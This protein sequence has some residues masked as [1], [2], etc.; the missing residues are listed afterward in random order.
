MLR[1]HSTNKRDPTSPLQHDE[2][3]KTRSWSSIVSGEPGPIVE[4]DTETELEP[5]EPSDMASLHGGE[6]DPT[7]STS[8]AA[9][10]TTITLD[11]TSIEAIAQLV[12]SN[13]QLKIN[14]IVKESVQ[15]ALLSMELKVQS[16]KE[17]NIEL[18]Q[19]NA[20]L[21]VRVYNLETQVDDIEQY[22][23]RN[24]LRVSGLTERHDEDTDKLILDLAKELDINLS[25]TDIDR[26]H[27]LG[28]P[29]VPGGRPRQIIVKFTSY[30][31][32]DMLF[33]KRKVM[34]DKPGFSHTYIN[35]DLTYK[36]SQ[37]LYE[38]RQAMKAKDIT[39]AWSFDG[40]LYVRDNSDTRRKLERQGDLEK[41]IDK[42]K[43]QQTHE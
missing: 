31:A 35:E 20:S 42:C 5:S 2:T 38:A 43:W 39:G 33:S 30:R 15:E 36:R 22:S 41:I 7:T 26:S 16:L 9:A 24:C 18:L 10:G 37:M 6:G 14:A 28:R 11:A 40:K 17:S 32:R 4:T 13:M 21:K 12:I 19:E 1:S 34:K 8:V 23:R 3:K 25:I 29:A 27:R